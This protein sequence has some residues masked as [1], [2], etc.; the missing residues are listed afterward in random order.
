MKECE[1]WEPHFEFKTSLLLWNF[2]IDFRSLPNVWQF[3]SILPPYHRTWP[4]C[5][6]WI[7]RHTDW[8]AK[9]RNL[10]N[11]RL[12]GQVACGEQEGF[13][14]TIPHASKYKYSKHATIAPDAPDTRNKGTSNAHHNIFIRNPDQRPELH[15][16]GY[17]GYKRNV[18]FMGKF[19]ECKGT[20]WIQL[21]GQQRLPMNALYR[22]IIK[23]NAIW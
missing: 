21:Q 20:S 6:Q 23:M 14:I 15:L 10:L 16:Q 13:L 22:T 1:F 7:Q 3:R 17:M 9:K 18:A 8:D 11:T 2:K 4:L 12:P 19:V 5:M